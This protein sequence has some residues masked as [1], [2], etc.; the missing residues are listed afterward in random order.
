TSDDQCFSLC[1]SGFIHPRL[2]GFVFKTAEDG[3]TAGMHSPSV[4]NANLNAAEDADDFEDGFVVDIGIAQ[5]EFYAA[6]DGGSFAGLEV[7]P[8]IAALAT[9]KNGGGVERSVGFAGEFGEMLAKFLRRGG[10]SP[11]EIDFLAEEAPRFEGAP[12]HQQSDADDR[13]GPKVRKA[14]TKEAEFVEL[15]KD[16]GGN[17]HKSEGAVRGGDEIR[18]SKKDKQQRPKA[19]DVIEG[20]DAHVVEEQSNSYKK[21]DET[22]DESPVEA[23]MEN[24]L[25]CSSGLVARLIHQRSPRTE[26]KRLRLSPESMAVRREFQSTVPVTTA[27]S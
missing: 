26:A 22:P 6:E 16:A 15:K 20:K 23:A 13:Q 14:Q 10:R 9:A 27:A 8:R 25:W 19:V 4:G 18:D 12:D 3:Q 24:D 7:L 1:A 2:P 11:V 17:Q 21:D 5:V